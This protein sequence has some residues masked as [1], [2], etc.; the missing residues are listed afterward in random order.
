MYTNGQK[1]NIFCRLISPE[2]GIGW[3]IMAIAYIAVTFLLR[4]FNLLYCNDFV[5]GTTC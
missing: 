5:G 3:Q 1:Q 2:N 4:I